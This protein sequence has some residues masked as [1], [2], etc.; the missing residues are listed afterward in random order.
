MIRQISAER[1]EKLG[2]WRDRT[3]IRRLKTERR[4]YI[5]DSRAI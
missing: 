4:V 1:N 3:K 5:K 2:E